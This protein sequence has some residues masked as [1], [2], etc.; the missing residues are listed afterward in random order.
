MLKINLKN[1]VIFLSGRILSESQ[2]NIIKAD[3][4]VIF[5]NMWLHKMFL[6]KNFVAKKHHESFVFTPDDSTFGINSEI[7]FAR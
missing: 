1:L 2:T 4:E 5:R 7:P 3:S 6:A